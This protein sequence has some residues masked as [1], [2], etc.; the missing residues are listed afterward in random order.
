MNIDEAEKIYLEGTRDSAYIG[1]DSTF[2]IAEILKCT[3]DSR[4]P[5]D[6]ECAPDEEIIAFLGAKRG[7]YKIISEQVDFN[8]RDEEAVRYNEIYTP[9]VPLDLS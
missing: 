5:G 6:P 9:S 8:D 1:E 7:L 2:G 3:E 4:M